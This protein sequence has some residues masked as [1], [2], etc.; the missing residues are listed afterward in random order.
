[1]RAN[2]ALSASDGNNLPGAES[3]AAAAV[4]SAGF[5]ERVRRACP[6]K[7]ASSCACCR[8]LIAGPGPP[9]GSTPRRL[10]SCRVMRIKRARSGSAIGLQ[11]VSSPPPNTRNGLPFCTRLSCP[12]SDL[13]NAVGRTMAWLRPEPARAASKRSFSNWNASLGFCTQMAESRVKCSTPRRLAQLSRLRLASKSTSRLSRIPPPRLAMQDTTASARRPDRARVSAVAS[14]IVVGTRVR[15][16]ARAACAAGSLDVFAAPV[17]W[18][19]RAL[20]HWRRGGRART[21]QIS[22]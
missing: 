3:S 12:L 2:S 21:G 20:R 15:R 6:L 10:L 16:A 1:M 5:S 14:V 4:S 11:R 19:A 8:G 18:P 13:K 9:I 17:N 22:V 7:S